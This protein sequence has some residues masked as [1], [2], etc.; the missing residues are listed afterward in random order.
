[1]KFRDIAEELGVSIATVSRVYNG[2]KGVGEK[3]RKK[4][5]R[6]WRQMIIVLMQEQETG[7]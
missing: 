6:F 1:M 3:T 5:K 7:H 2:Q 4:L